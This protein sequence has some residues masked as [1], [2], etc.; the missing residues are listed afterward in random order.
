VHEEYGL[1]FVEQ[2]YGFCDGVE[3]V[4]WCVYV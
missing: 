4:V 2:F 1:V 3:L